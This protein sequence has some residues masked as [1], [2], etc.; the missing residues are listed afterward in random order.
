MGEGFLGARLGF[1][2]A[3][4]QAIVGSAPHALW[5]SRKRRG[6]T[7]IAAKPLSDLARP[8]Q[9]ALTR[10]LALACVSPW[11]I[12]TCKATAA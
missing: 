4:T 3:L 8:A 11:D 6:D 9:R 12:P 5:L 1:E 10:V 2:G 7:G